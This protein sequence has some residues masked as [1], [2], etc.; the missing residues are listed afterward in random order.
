MLGLCPKF[1]MLL[2]LQPKKHVL[3]IGSFHL[4]HTWFKMTLL[5]TTEWEAGS[6]YA[7]LLKGPAKKLGKGTFAMI[8]WNGGRRGK[9]WS[10]FISSNC[11]DRMASNLL[12]SLK[13]GQE[14]GCRGFCYCRETKGGLW[15][16]MGKISLARRLICSHNT[17]LKNWRKKT[18]MT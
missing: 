1:P 9:W 2:L 3:L 11:G 4:K 10:I 15:R 18:R 17:K 7:L 16:V 6:F 5:R 12:K 8:E 13:I 14:R